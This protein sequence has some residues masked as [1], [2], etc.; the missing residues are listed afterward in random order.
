MPG[1]PRVS[2]RITGLYYFYKNS[3]L[4]FIVLEIRC[5]NAL[6]HFTFFRP[7]SIAS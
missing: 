6:Y 5:L 1:Y 3:F 2:I 7:G 4:T